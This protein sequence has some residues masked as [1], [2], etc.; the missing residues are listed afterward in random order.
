[1]LRPARLADL[2]ED[3]A[4]LLGTITKVAS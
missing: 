2:G 1:V 3:G 4:A